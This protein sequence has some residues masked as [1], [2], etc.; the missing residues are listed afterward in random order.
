M[1]T[2]K[3]WLLVLVIVVTMLLSACATYD[4]SPVYNHINKYVPPMNG[5][6]DVVG[7]QSG[8]TMWGVSQVLQG[9]VGTSV[10]ENAQYPGR[11]VMSWAMP[12]GMRGFV[13]VDV[14]Y[15]FSEDAAPMQS[16]AALITGN[17]TSV[18]GWR[19][20]EKGLLSSGWSIADSFEIPA[21][22]VRAITTGY[23]VIIG[24]SQMFDPFNLLR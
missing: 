4:R 19:H 5:A 12:E 1:F 14:G 6:L 22:A 3:S 17:L 15:L 7:L 13:G 8:S 21:P 24:G 18:K 9:K 11:Y 10:L 23:W 16:N 20:L 2:S